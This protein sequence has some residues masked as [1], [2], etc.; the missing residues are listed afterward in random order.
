MSTL[1][2]SQM[3]RL[4]RRLAPY[5]DAAL[6]AY[7]LAGFPIMRYRRHAIEALSLRRGETVVDLGCGTGLNVPLLREAVGP[8]GHVIGVDLSGAM[9]E[10]AEARV[11]STG[12]ANVELVQADAAEYV[13]PSDIGGILSTLAITIVDEYDDVIRRGA[14]ALRPGGRMAL[15]GLKKPG[16]W[17]EWLLRLAVWVNKPFGVTLD[18]ADRHPWESVQRHLREACFR[19]MYLGAAY[20][21]VGEAP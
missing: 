9:L 5:Y 18:Y 6:W 12:W 19:E 10:E 2:T 16:G 20:L 3:R 14:E 15:F 11:R 17:P 13:F 4:Y 1:S 8:E 21:S 7:Y